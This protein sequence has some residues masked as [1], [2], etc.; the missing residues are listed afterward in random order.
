MLTLHEK[1]KDLLIHRPITLT[2]E[3]IEKDTGIS[4][5][6]LKELSVSEKLSNPGVNSIQKLYEY[7]SGKPLTL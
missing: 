3:Q 6:W 5:R 4:K 7:L 2:Y 1:T